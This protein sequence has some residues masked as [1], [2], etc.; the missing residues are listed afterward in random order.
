MPGGSLEEK[1]GLKESPSTCG[2]ERQDSALHSLDLGGGR[3][4]RG[5]IRQKQ[6]LSEIFP[7]KGQK[8]EPR[9]QDAGKRGRRKGGS[10]SL[11]IS[12]WFQLWGKDRKS[13]KSSPKDF[14]K[15]VTLLGSIEKSRTVHATFRKK[16]IEIETLRE[17]TERESRGN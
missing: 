16:F 1:T 12:V 7:M 8:M 3:R 13:I 6:M 9:P 5:G 2:Q 15:L 17:G 4:E 11:Y 10:Y 14:R